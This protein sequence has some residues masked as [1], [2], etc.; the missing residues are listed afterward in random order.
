[1]YVDNDPLVLVHARAL[2][3]ST[4]EGSCHYVDASL[5]EPEKILRV[6]ADTLDLTQ[7]VALMLMEILGHVAADDEACGLVRRLLAGLPAG[8]FL[9][10]ADGTTVVTSDFEEAQDDYDD[11]GADPYKLRG[12]AQIARFF[13]GL[14]L[15]APGVVPC[16]EWRAEVGRLSPPAEVEPLAGIARKP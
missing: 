3:T 6:A 9:V 8:S 13:S 12:P 16:L 11:T 10:I 4:P 15:L 7:P 5:D 1:V 2:L 14:D